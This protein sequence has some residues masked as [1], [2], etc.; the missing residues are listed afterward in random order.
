MERE[1]GQV[2]IVQ[3]NTRA[4]I[5]FHNFDICHNFS[6]STGSKILVVLAVYMHI[7]NLFCYDPGGMCY[8]HHVL[9]AL[10]SMQYFMAEHN[11]IFIYVDS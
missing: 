6:V 7:Y 8:P 11:E 9:A 5:L 4:T 1:N 2:I 3:T 10:N